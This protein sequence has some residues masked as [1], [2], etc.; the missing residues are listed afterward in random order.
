M[1]QKFEKDNLFHIMRY[2]VN[3][4]TG[5]DQRDQRNDRCNRAKE[6]DIGDYWIVG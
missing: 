6:L 2:N 1:A 4:L 3:I 5:I